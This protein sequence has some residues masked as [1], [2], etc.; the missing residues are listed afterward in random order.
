M[1]LPFGI[2]L[3]LAAIIH[4][5]VLPVLIFYGLPFPSKDNIISSKKHTTYSFYQN[6][7]NHT[8]HTSIV[9]FLWKNLL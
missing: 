4:V 7:Q 9:Y 1:A 3:D 2:Y 6:A 5:C 8:L